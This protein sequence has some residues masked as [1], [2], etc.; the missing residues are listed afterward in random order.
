[1]SERTYRDFDLLVEKSGESGYRA[2]VIGSPA[3]ET[4]SVAI[5]VPFSEQDI[6][7]FLLRI[8]TPRAAVRRGS[9]ANL[10]PMIEEF[11]AKLFDGVFRDEIRVALATS[12]DMTESDDVGLRIRLRL[13]DAPELAD[14]PWEFLYDRSAG[15]FLALSDWTPVVRFLE[16]R[17]RIRPLTVT[18]PLR[19][20]L[21]A[22]SPVDFDRLDSAGEKSRLRDAL[23]DLV[24]AN[25]V[26]VE[27]E[28]TGTLA[29][30]QRRLRLGEYHVFHFIGHGAFDE[31]HDDGVLYFEGPERRS[32][33]V[34]GRALGELLH[35]HRSL[36]LAVL[37]ACEGARSGREDP[38][39]GT[40]QSLVRQGIPAV[41]A[42]QFEITDDAALTFAHSLYQAVGDGYPLDASMAEARK[43][44][45]N[46]PNDV[47]WAT[48]VLH[49]RA[50]D[51]R[52]FAVQTNLPHEPPS[53]ALAGSA[54][55]NRTMLEPS[56]GA[57]ATGDNGGHRRRKPGS[58]TSGVLPEAGLQKS[59]RGATDAADGAHPWFVGRADV[60][61]TVLGFLQ[62]PGRSYRLR[63]GGTWGIGKT[64]L[65]KEIGA[66]APEGA[67]VLQVRAGAHVPSPS[68]SATGNETLEVIRNWNSYTDLVVDLI[69][70]MP[71]TEEW[72]AL[73]EQIHESQNVVARVRDL[74]LRVEVT[75]ERASAA[76]IEADIEAQRA[77]IE[78]VFRE[79]LDHVGRSTGAVILVDEFDRL[80]DYQV[81]GWLLRLVSAPESVVVVIATRKGG[82]N[83]AA[84]TRDFE[85]RDLRRFGNQEV[86]TY[87]KRRLGDD[88]VSEHL[89]DRVLEFSDG[90]PQAVAMAADLIEQRRLT[91]GDL[92]L[93]D[94]S[95]MPGRATSA[96][97]STIVRE[98]PEEDV[99][100]LLKRGRL[101][102]RIDA[103]LI[104][105]LLHDRRYEE[106]DAE[107]QRRADNALAKVREYSFV[108]EYDG[109][110]DGLGR[111]RFHEYITRAEAPSSDDI[112]TVDEEAVHAQ[113]AAYLEQCHDTWDEEHDTESPY[114][115]L[116]KLESHSWQAL[117]REWLHHMSYLDRPEWREF[118][119][120]AFVRVFLQTFWWWRCYIKYDY[121]DDLLLDW[122]A[123]VRRPRAWTQRLHDLLES[124]PTGYDKFDKGSWQKVEYAMRGLQDDLNLAG[125]IPLVDK[126]GADQRPRELN[127]LNNRRVVRALTSLFRGHAYMYRTGAA[128]LAV[129]HFEDALTHL[130][131]A[132]TEQSTVAWTTFEFAELRLILNDVD[133]ASECL[134]EAAEL[135]GELSDEDPD[136]ELLANIQ[137]LHA[138]I[139]SSKGDQ[140]AAI[141]A[142]ARAVLR[143]YAFLN[144]PEPPDPYTVAFYDE[145]RARAAQRLLDLHE[146]NPDD[147]AVAA[148]RLLERLQILRRPFGLEDDAGEA[149]EKR[150]LAALVALLP[151]P[152]Q[153]LGDEARADE[154]FAMASA[155]VLQKVREDP[156]DSE[157]A[158][159][160]G[161]QE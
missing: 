85:E 75:G 26:V 70:D 151:S 69:R 84:G 155:R 44:I 53:S 15:R 150:D 76:T 105:Y 68:A 46:M 72:D 92:L 22:A 161:P 17:G 14:L 99:R 10:R 107:Q 134:R 126:E 90:L 19:I 35:D 5:E 127:H 12:V 132:P 58:A 108:E 9:R 131:A 95:S 71:Q 145:M 109:G 113:L 39:A 128:D 40:A 78:R 152:P 160:P 112:L 16:L 157:L 32:Q 41:I 37:N 158:Q 93:H 138:D 147:A 49:M 51:G 59:R 118:A 89:V 83:L 115:R 148:R 144:E 114:R 43:S 140:P 156:S 101:A 11:G 73:S 81:G 74:S 146:Q 8:G 18:P 54:D 25:R 7:I 110:D 55:S 29:G 52:V 61:G 56:N 34:T 48:P 33:A 38:F 27:D 141:D 30:L 4:G 24:A 91:G 96:L 65:L 129:R 21:M 3:G 123:L 121:C 154:T 133:A 149:L 143:A 125:R 67:A 63:A 94:V 2:R 1:M 82:P 100:S 124:Y 119:E 88:A 120:M 77:Q 60:I 57:S 130:K 28:P 102:R 136:Y 139:A 79:T 80:R 142:T 50:G 116:Y 87:L 103:D 153:G 6:E 137:R 36:R 13:T 86:S 97:L 117:A 47:E 31:T 122:E 111:Y 98:V 62:Q 104:H 45:R 106:G 23:A 66:R 159:L 135:L 20:L 42:M 64:S